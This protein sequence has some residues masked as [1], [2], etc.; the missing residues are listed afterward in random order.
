MKNLTGALC[1]K[2]P[3]LFIALI[4][5]TTIA[6]SQQGNV[7]GKVI[8]GE[9]NQPLVGAT[10]I[11]K[12]QAGATI[13]T[14]DG[15]F[16]IPLSHDS[17]VAEITS[18]G[19]YSMQMIFRTGQ[20]ITIRL[21]PSASSLDEVIVTGYTQERKKDIKGAVAVVKMSDVLKETNANL[22]TSLQGRVPGLDISTN[23]AP[24]S[25]IFVNLRG[26]G[27][28]NNNTPP[29]LIID[30]VPTY[31]FNGLSPNDIESIQ[32]L[33]DA[34]SAAVYGARASSGVLVITTKKGKSRDVQVN[35]NAFYGI[36]TLRK[37]LDL[38]NAEEYGQVLW[39]GFKNDN[40]GNTPNDPIYG[41]GP[42]P[43]IPEFID[44][45]KNTP[46]G[47]TDWQKEVF[48]PAAN[49]SMDIG[50]SK[51]ADRS[52]FYF[53]VNYFKE[54]GLAQQTFYERLTTRINS[55]FKVSNKITI[56]ENLNIGFLRGN[57]EN[58]GRVLEAAL[59]QQA[60]VP[61]KDNLG[62]W[63]GP[64]SS[65]GDYRNPVGD[66][67][68]FKDNIR[69]GWRTFGNVF[70]DIELIKGLVYH[71]SF[72]VNHYV[73][74]LKAFTPTYVMG[75]FSNNENSLTEF[76][77][78]T[79]D[80]TSSHTL[81]Y[82][83]KRGKHNLQLLAGY[84][85]INNKFSTI[86]ASAR[87]FFLETPS[88]LYLSAGLPTT[89]RGFGSEYGLIGQFGRLDYVFN[90]RYLIG[91][92]LRRDGSSRFG[93]VNRYGNF[94]AASAA[95]RIS[96]EAFFK[97][98]KSSVSDLKLR[99]SW[100]QNGNDNIKDYN[101][102][103]FYGPNIDYA[104]YDVLGSNNGAATGFIV[105]SLGN[106]ST[107]WEAVQQTNI[108][109]DLG[110]FNNRLTVSADYYI[111]NSKDLLYQ[112]P[113]PATVGEGTAPFINVGNIRNNGLEVLISYRSIGQKKINYVFDL[114][115]TSN[116]N[117]VLSVGK[118][119][120]DVIYPGNGILKKG[121]PIGEFYGYIV[122]G[123]F[124]SQAELDAAVQD[125][126][127]LGGLKF[128]DVN[129][130]K[131][132]TADDRTTIGSPLP[133]VMLGLNGNLSY[134]R[135]SL[136]FF[137]DSK[138][139]NKIFDATKWNTDFLGYAS[140]HGKILLDAWSPE[141]TDSKVPALSNNFSQFDKANSTYFISDASYV[142]LKSATLGYDLPVD[143]LKSVKIRKLSIFVQ[144]QNM[145]TITS[146]KGYDFEPLNA[147]IGETGVIRPTAYPHSKSVSFGLNLGL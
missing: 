39:Q 44:P 140:N 110:L 80:L 121:L 71:G 52:N 139:G 144:V 56:G 35:F 77:D 104:N 90:D 147:S 66:L 32:V 48:K 99:V 108:G 73:S 74:G 92:S 21:N 143:K 78:E 112:A 13:T 135:I 57:R 103:T 53:G 93:K 137:I 125:G 142:R 6:W 69:T 36:K 82:A 119:G 138:L 60:I 72:A 129:G 11:I 7:T 117:R 94:A 64:F 37:K 12:G 19:M 87:N 115:F 62:N 106:P 96:E 41:N 134:K 2:K 102:A 68:L 5:L 130:D 88:F 47:N 127:H 8:N 58:E 118:D 84:E 46:S 49:M 145:L 63:A 95:W 45:A 10:I 111:K 105:S 86:S 116:K 59:L 136:N 20:D 34:A 128:R 76:R 114:S 40:N 14:A 16:S 3:V 100:G 98:L 81:T 1:Y 97:N 31:D 141:N 54:E 9:N 23:G 29:L 27:S 25:N 51:A 15:K 70:T 126:K 123:L 85:W 109:L 50:L 91:G 22:I 42:Q 107:K 124:Q 26:L 75:S 18:T 28:F 43:V 89:N 17:S 113:I 55:S 4:F 132:V 61:L 33:K 133:K 146:F 101:Y 120:N 122:D 79:L 30:G 38:L 131:K 65:L 83:L 67:N 24:G